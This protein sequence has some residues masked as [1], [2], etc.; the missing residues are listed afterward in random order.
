[1]PRGPPV[2]YRVGRAVVVTGHA[3]G[4]KSAVKP[5]WAVAGIWGDVAGRAGGGAAPAR[6]TKFHV[7]LERLVGNH[8]MV[9]KLT[10]DV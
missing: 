10:Y 1:M 2:V 7:Y 8:L 5:L 9:E 3:A 4:A 6:H